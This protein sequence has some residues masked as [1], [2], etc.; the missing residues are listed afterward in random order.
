MGCFGTAYTEPAKLI[1][2]TLR[3]HYQILNSHVI[4]TC[5]HKQN[6]WMSKIQKLPLSKQ[7]K[8][9]YQLPHKQYFVPETS[10]EKLQLR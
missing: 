3:V 1:Q 10:N 8:Q 9:L 6:I 7:A 5:L 2:D 4:S